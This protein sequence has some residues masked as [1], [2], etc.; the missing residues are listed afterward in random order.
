[1]NKLSLDYETYCDLDLRKVGLD[2]YSTDP[3]CRVLMAAYRIDEGPLQQWEAHESRLPRELRNAL[4]DPNTIR[5]AYNAQFERIITKR[6]LQVKTPL[7]GWRCAL[8]LAYS[9]SYAGSLEE[10]GEQCGLPL[11]K[12]KMKD[13]KRLIRMFCMPNKP[14]KSQPYLFRNWLTDPE[15]WELF[16]EYNRQD[17]ITEEALVK[18]LLPFPLPDN[19]WSDYH[20]DQIINDRGIPLDL[21]FVE[22]IIWMSAR[23]KAEL[24][25]RMKDIT[26]IV[27]P[28]STPQLLPW[29][30]EH[31]YPYADLRKESVEKTLRRIKKKDP[32]ISMSKEAI[33][34]VRLRQWAAR[35]SVNKAV[36]AKAVVG[37]NNR[38]RFLYQFCGAGR[39]WRSSG[40]RIQP[41]NM[42]RTPKIFEAEE[43]SMPLDIATDLIRTG[44]YDMLE[45]YVREP[46]VALTGTMRGMF[47]APDGHNFTVC[48]FSSVESVGLGYITGCER[49]LDV[50]RS[51]RD[52]YRDFGTMF[53]KKPYDEITR[54][55]R[56]ICKPPSLACGYRLGPGKDEAGVKT[57]LLAYA[58]NMGVEMTLEEA[59][60]AVT[61]FR[62]GYP[63]VPKYWYE[64]EKAVRYVLRTHK[65]YQ[66]GC[67]TF[68]W[69]KPYMLIR[70]PSGH[71][72]YYYKPRLETRTIYTGRTI[73]RRS[74]GFSE[75]GYSAG[76]VFEDEE[77]YERQIFTYMGKHQK[78]GKWIRLEGHGG[79]FT[80]N[81]DQALTRDVLMVGL[82]RLHKA[83][84]NLVGH[85]HDEAKAITKVGDNYYTLERMREEMTAPIDWLPGFPLNAAG[86]T[87]P[88]YRK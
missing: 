50:F 10:V 28:N 45:L 6:V 61:T 48:D 75:D 53:Y 56:Q 82:R 33:Q 67:V 51:G 37:S 62:E 44:N 41:Q 69:K 87:S 71:C 63:E 80:E 11:D 1:M 60:R 43:D 14:T 3:S 4:E 55:E 77:T 73:R 31:G 7:R 17:V 46:M 74:R 59:V 23:R 12:Q 42:T 38:A 39:T 76:F 54:A 15:D 8:V 84:F 72:I 9:H 29:L 36:T 5:Y 66:V 13:G 83:G 88:Y 30:L 34:V 21:D 81:I 19:F 2:R 18:R 16:K 26:G 64:T 78:T 70:L 24:H 20:L 32:Y 85:A 86:F 49:I 25:Q 58:E 27:N 22:N 57:G 47:R 65:P 79:V 68:D 40:R 52:M 35:T